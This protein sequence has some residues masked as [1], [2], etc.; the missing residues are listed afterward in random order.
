MI[1]GYPDANFTEIVESASEDPIWVVIKHRTG[2]AIEVPVVSK[3]KPTA[4]V[5]SSEG[6]GS[7]LKTHA[8]DI[9]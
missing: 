1:H 3:G 9:P 4:A 8:S 5:K 6:N 7:V 2:Q